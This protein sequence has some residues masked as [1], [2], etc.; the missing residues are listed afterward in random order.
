MKLELAISMISIME[1]LR[2]ISSAGVEYDPL[3]FDGRPGMGHGC[4]NFEKSYSKEPFMLDSEFKEMTGGIQSNISVRQNKQNA[5]GNI[6]QKLCIYL[7]KD[8]TEDLIQENKSH[9]NPKSADNKFYPPSIDFTDPFAG[10]IDLH[11]LLPNYV[12]P[13]YLVLLWKTPYL[14]VYHNKL[15]N[16]YIANKSMLK[17]KG[18]G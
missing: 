15:S 16:F 13:P 9:Q 5:I 14:G 12:L 10:K 2:R 8:Q 6:S 4:A 7:F 1:F 3:I 17:I 18:E 11:N